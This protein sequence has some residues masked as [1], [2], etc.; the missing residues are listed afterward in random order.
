[1][2]IEVVKRPSRLSKSNT[3]WL[4]IVRKFEALQSD[5]CLRIT[6]LSKTEIGALRQQAYREVRARTFVRIDGN[7]SILFLYKKVV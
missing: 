7:K 1:M 5:E 4:Q 2:E 3:N 6:G